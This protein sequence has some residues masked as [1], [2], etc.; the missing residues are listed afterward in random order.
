MK[1]VVGMSGGVDSSVAALL[2]KDQGHEVIGLFMKNWE[3]KDE[4]GNCTSDQDF[5]D[6]R[7]VCGILNIPYYGI[8]F[9]KEYEERVFSYFLDEYKN[10]R[11]PNPDVLCNREIK[12]GPFLQHAMKLGAEKIATG[13]FCGVEQKNGKYFLKKVA[14]TD[15]DQTYFLNQL[16]QDQLSNVIFPLS[17]LTKSQIREIAKKNGLPNADKKDSTGICFIGERNFREFLKNYLPMQ[18]GEIRNLDG[19]LLGSHIG[20]MY[21]TL[22]QRKGLGIGGVRGNDG[23]RWFVV[24][25]DLETNTLWV[26]QGEDRCLF[27]SYLRASE[28]NWIPEVPKK[29]EL[30]CYA[31]VRYRQVEQKCKVALCDNNEV[32]VSFIDKQRAVSPGQFVVF[33]DKENCLGGGKINE[34]YE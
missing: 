25:K 13:H 21:Y 9:A 12:F 28:L 27:T 26:S 30:E 29:K 7:K 34:A 6:V 19:Q 3:E 18:K 1:I 32:V 31:K 24:K 10:G 23:D 4:A 33:Y 16:R 8:N 20:L 14:D 2:L 11:T 17:N 15:K 22:G 5:E